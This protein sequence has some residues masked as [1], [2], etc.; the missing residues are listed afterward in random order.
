MTKKDSREAK[1]SRRK[2]LATALPVGVALGT[3]WS[4]A[5]RAVQKS[6]SHKVGRSVDSINQRTDGTYATVPLRKE[7]ILIGLVQSR[8]RQVDPRNPRPGL[9]ANLAH[10]LTLI[11]DAQHVGFYP[12][13]DLLHFHEFALTG[14]SDTWSRAEAL[15]AAIELPGEETE[16]IGKKAREHGCYIIFGSYVR[17][18]DW[19]GHV[20]SIATTIGPDGR[21]ISRSWKACNAH[22]VFPNPNFALFTSTIFNNLDRFVEMYGW[23]AVVPV[24][25]T[26]IGNFTTT[27]VQ[28]DPEFARVAAMKG[29][30]I[31]LRDATGGFMAIDQQ[32]TALYNQM[33]CC[34]VNNAVSP[35]NPG[36]FP[37]DAYF[38]HSAIYGPTGEV[39]AKAGADGEEQQVVAEI[40]IGSFREWHR[41]PRI[42]MALYRPEYD[43]YVGPYPS[44]LF[45]SAMP[46]DTTEAARFFQQ[47]L[48]WK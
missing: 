42:A 15:R 7:S 47:S 38:G 13:K 21:I 18:P 17:D 23:D 39:V 41:Q 30:E 26:D 3:S 10:M 35:D 48:R 43:R 1:Y 6:Q 45:A 25:R 2:V 37:S 19:P 8:V 46:N 28:G 9:K 5:G 27:S 31:F 12:P 22:G 32:A 20:L 29:C 40:P 34:V 16:A 11:D 14:Y 44:N 33:Y 4:S 24:I 36:F